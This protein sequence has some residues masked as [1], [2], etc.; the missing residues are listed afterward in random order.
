M[1]KIV[2]RAA[3]ALVATL[4]LLVPES[5]GQPIPPMSAA[6]PILW[7]PGLTHEG[8]RAVSNSTEI[9]TNY[10]YRV[11][12]ANPSV[13]AWRTALTVHQGEAHLYLS[14]GVV[15]TTT[16]YDFKSDRAGSDGFVLGSTQFS[17]NEVWYILVQANAATRFSL[18]SGAPFVQDLGSVAADDSSGSGQVIIGPEGIRY[19]SAQ[20]PTDMLAW[21]LWLDGAT[22]AILLKK[23]GVP[24]PSANLNELAQQAQALVVPPYLTGGQ[25]YFIGVVGN[26]GTTNILDSRQQSIVD[27]AYGTATAT[28]DVTG[29]PYT[30]YRIHVPAQQIAWRVSAP[31]SKGNPNVSLRRNTVPNEFN[32]DALSEL[33][34]PLTDNIALVPPVLSDGTFYVTVWA[35]NKH[36]FVFQNGPAVV[37]EID[38]ID[39]IV[40]DDPDRVGWRYY[41]I[42]DISQQLGSL[43]WHLSVSNFAPG[44][45][46]A[47]RRNAAPGIWSFRNPT[48]GTATYYDLLSV[49]QTLQD[50]GHQAD[51][52][53]VGVY[54]PTNALGNFR[55]TTK[56]LD[57]GPLIPTWQTA[58][59]LRTN[60]TPGVWE[61]FRLDL[62]AGPMPGLGWDLRLTDVSGSPLL[63]VRRDLFPTNLSSGMTLPV[64]NTNWGT[65]IQW[66]AGA[67]WTGRMFGNVGNTNEN[68]RLLTMPLN[69]PLQAGRY[70]VGVQSSAGST[71]AVSFTLLSRWMGETMGI[72]VRTLNWSGASASNTVAL[73]EADYYAVVIPPNTRSFKARLRMLSGEAMLVASKDN[74]PNVSSTIINPVPNSGGK[75]IQKTGDEYFTLLPPRGSNVLTAGTYYLAVIGEGANPPD[76]QHIGAGS[77]SYILETLGAMPQPNLGV[78]SDELIT[79]GSLA[80][81]DVNAYH[82]NTEPSV[83]GFWVLIENAVGNPVAVS[84]PEIDFADPG[85]GNNGFASDL[86]GN[87]GGRVN[88]AGAGK[89][90]AVANPFSTET[91][92]VKARQS[93][94]SYPDASYTLRISRIE[95]DL[96]P[97]DGGLASV[98]NAD[99]TKGHFF[100]VDV[101]PDALGWDLRLTN[102]TS[103]DPILVVRRDYLPISLGT[104]LG[105][106]PA[107]D[108][109][110]APG[111][112]WQAGRDWTERPLS[113]SGAFED[114]RILAMGVGRP[115]Q[116]G[117][118]YIGIFSA[119]TEPLSFSVLSRGIGEEMSIPVTELAYNGGVSLVTNLAPR[120]VSYYSLDIPAGTPSWKVHLAATR[121]ESLLMASKHSL[122]NVL[123]AP[124][125]NLTNS[126]GRKMQKS[127]EEHFLLLP[128]PGTNVLSPGR[129]F[130]AVA[131][132]GVSATAGRVGTGSVD[133]RITSVGPAPIRQLGELGVTDVVEQNDLVAGDTQIYQFTIPAGT[134]G[135]EARLEDR[136]ANPVM[137]L[138]GGARAGPAGASQTN[139]PL[140]PYGN[141]DGDPNGIDVHPSLI[142]V[143]NVTNNIYTLVVMARSTSGGYTNSSYTLRLNASGTTTLDFNG[144]TYAV[145]DQAVRTWKYFRVTVPASAN[146]WDVRLQNVNN[147]QPRMVIRRESLPSTLLSSPWSAP[148]AATSWP[149]NAQWAPGMDWTRRSFS[150]TNATLNQDSQ[151]F[152]CG[153]GRPLEPGTY[154]VGVYNNS[155]TI[156]AE[157]SILSRG[158]GPDLAIPLIDIPFVGSYSATLPARDAAYFR[159]VVPSNSPSWKVKVTGDSG[160]A[161][162][163][164]LR[165][166]VP[167][168]DMNQP[169]GTLANG[170]GMQKAGNEHFVLLPVNGQT[171][172]PS[173]TNYFAVVS[174]GI[175]P[176]GPTRIGSGS[177]SFTFESEGAVP[178]NPLG[179]VTSEDLVRPDVLQAGEVKAYT[180]LVPSGTLGMKVRLENREGNPALILRYGDKIPDPGAPIPTPDVYGNEGGYASTE[181]H[182]ALYTV[183]NPLP[184][185]YTVS[186]KARPSS[187][188]I[189]PDA[190]YNLRVQE[191]LVPETNFSAD[192]N[193][194]GLS[195][196][197]TGILDD[198]ERVYFKFI[199]P[200]SLAGEPVAG[201]RLELVQSSGLA[202]MRVRKDILPSDATASTQMQF[203]T[204]S[205]AIVPPFLT[206][207]VWYVEVKGTG[208]TAFRLTSNPLILERPV[209]AMPLPGEPS[210]TPGVL[211]PLFGDSGID[212]NGFPLPGDSSTFLEQG[213]LHYYAVSVP[214]N[215]SGVLRAVLEAI[216]GNPDLYLRFGSPPT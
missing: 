71:Q 9:A 168:I 112:Q 104:S 28:N 20:V 29:Y 97:F 87:D 11:T 15:P 106:N 114:G 27:L 36:E 42:T 171:N 161:M 53:Y 151:I 109:D 150:S 14:R 73:R 26:P 111:E 116:P 102:V 196:V 35:T 101:P 17:P 60:I 25:Q 68:G 86:Y 144:G 127:G 187:T 143:G 91:V 61:Y 10:L 211:A 148:G 157:Y 82:F 2:I 126:T 125:S 38:Y 140:D 135:L 5:L 215:N 142:S 66:T 169:T 121:G 155:A 172:L 117:R 212:T 182:T 160:E 200:E 48:A 162:M 204:A 156:P 98:S 146:G 63:V 134:L 137:V 59:Y 122:P 99:G 166:T 201:W 78:L 77:S 210:E 88:G 128:P 195:N 191:I 65:G 12:T 192:Q 85:I 139:V 39:S 33:S 163:V 141:Q 203:T 170:K 149:I 69:R 189:Y 83:L 22:N 46:I 175:N 54:N 6:E 50:P 177:S 118:Y 213:T 72:P 18:I 51:V 74:L 70:Y 152:A 209:W 103:G 214:T 52:W 34:P 188:T 108:T 58:S 216:S 147:G 145:A 119:T 207:G 158:I 81:G 76:G 186:V 132:E 133:F 24:L 56:E 190:S 49:T 183:P 115:L 179:V 45:R 178:I 184:G 21:R 96:L 138:R 120:E 62:P 55:L 100:Y 90:I 110:W 123:I 131:S 32:N 93:S 67:D 79:T 185:L 124:N 165:G 199:I 75:N 13:G 113:S 16:R 129:Y 136:I 37:T 40:N 89:V 130:L 176:A 194:N 193:T 1:R 19:F 95:P 41:R 105:F 80:G 107:T 202:S 208:S 198:N 31:G 47:I 154:F 180:F 64:N 197:V 181:G 94:G 57:P 164:G 23:T 159:V 43:G 8:T 3:F 167:N 30:T 205:T 153:M 7:D 84:S 92:M 174:E 173:S 44:T 206:N 4:A